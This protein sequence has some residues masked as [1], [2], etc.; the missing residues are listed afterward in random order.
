MARALTRLSLS[1]LIVAAVADAARPVV[2]GRRIPTDSLQGGALRG[3][4]A[5]RIHDTGCQE[6]VDGGG[7]VEAALLQLQSRASETAGTQQGP[8]TPF[9]NSHNDFLVGLGHQVCTTGL[10]DPHPGGTITLSRLNRCRD[11]LARVVHHGNWIAQASVRGAGQ[12]QWQ[13]A[14]PGHLD[15]RFLYRGWTYEADADGRVVHAFM[16]RMT[17][18]SIRGGAPGGNDDLRATLNRFTPGGA[19]PD[20]AGHIRANCLGGDHELLNFIPQMQQNNQQIQRSIEVTA[21]NLLVDG[22]C[23]LDIH[24]RYNYANPANPHA[25]VD[26]THYRPN[27]VRYKITIPGNI[28]RPPC[29]TAGWDI[30]APGSTVLD[31]VYP[32]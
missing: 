21:R 1:I 29:F 23:M 3:G 13:P 22:Q 25:Q 15:G 31:V 26:M 6:G 7:S 2:A 27:A 11:H 17:S 4:R 20:D 8:H 14:G 5:A 19:P 18:G 24:L 16:E 12:P 10:R 30:G 28:G 9:D 32:N